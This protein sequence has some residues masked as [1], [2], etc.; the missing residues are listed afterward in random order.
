[1]PECDRVISSIEH[2]YGHLEIRATAHLHLC[3]V[4]CREDVSGRAEEIR[5]FCDVVMNL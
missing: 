2:F 5:A 1:M 3:A 4:S